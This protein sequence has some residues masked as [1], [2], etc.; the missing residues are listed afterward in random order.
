MPK[1]LK[2]TEFRGSWP[3][4][5]S[6]PPQSSRQKL[7]SYAHLWGVGGSSAS[8]QRTTS[9]IWSREVGKQWLDLLKVEVLP[10][11]P[12]R[13]QESPELGSW[14]RSLPFS[15]DTAGKRWIGLFLLTRLPSQCRGESMR[16]AGPPGGTW[17]LPFP[18]QWVQQTH[19]SRSPATLLDDLTPQL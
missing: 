6:L 4:T 18:P 17:N 7:C 2:E 15:L 10:P 16:P 19:V 12:P 11:D 14:A 13:Q 5:L 9:L 1:G 8:L 3:E